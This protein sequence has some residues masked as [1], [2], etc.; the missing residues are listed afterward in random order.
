ML[1][2]GIWQASQDTGFQR[3]WRRGLISASLLAEQSGALQGRFERIM[4]QISLSN[5]VARTTFPGRFAELDALVEG[6]LLENY[7]QR[8][9]LVVHDWAV[10]GGTTSLEWYQRLKT[11]F[12]RV[13]FVASDLALY[14][15][16][17][18][19]GNEAYILEPDG[20]PI[21]YTRPPFVVSLV[22]MNHWLYAV[23]RLVQMRALSQ[24][25][26]LASEIRIPDWEGLDGDP[27]PVSLPPFTLRRLPILHPAVLAARSEDFQIRRHSVFSPLNEPVDVIRTMNIFN[28]AYFDESRL[29]EGADAVQNSLKPRGI[30]IV[31]RT[32]QEQPPRH[33]ATVLRKQVDGWELLHRVGEGSE[34]EPLTQ[35]RSSIKS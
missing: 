3:Q 2:I 25:K 15:I 12:P 32:I 29:R 8:N 34:I 11:P 35:A 28:R 18:R 14:L 24:W 23:N 10:S 17:A 27:A 7:P 30:W 33:N 31:G 4:T 9:P 6:V 1:K 21:Q 20:T 22:R 26:E 5:L 13:Q 16:E 19:R